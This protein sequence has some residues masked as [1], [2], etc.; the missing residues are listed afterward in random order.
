MADID[1]ATADGQDRYVPTATRDITSAGHEGVYEWITEN[2]V[3]E[4]MRA[5]DFGCGT[6][7]GAAMLAGAG[8]TVDGV[9]NS[10]AA[11]DYATENFGAPGVRFFVADLMKPLPDVCAPRSYDLVASSE[12]LEHVVDPFAFVR[13]MADSVNDGGVCFVGTPNRLWSIDHVP[14]GHLLARSHLMEFTPPA[15]IALLHTVFDEVSLMVRIFPEGA[16]ATDPPPAA[17]A[18]PPPVAKAE[19]LPAGRPRSQL[20]RVPAALVRRVA[21][22]AVERIK[23]AVEPEQ[24]PAPAAPE[25]PAPREWLASDIIW[26]LADDPTVDMDRA[27]GLAAVCHKPR[28]LTPG[29]SRRRASRS[30]SG[31]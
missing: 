19:P 8:A 28:R 7:Y 17:T 18:E 11:I 24:P 4:G 3:T 9:D 14:D 31:A 15:L 22:G 20:I 30:F 26:A 10:P 29:R 23:R 21:P 5:L 25:A 12:V 27:V 6:G 2:L 13:G 16:M 1:L